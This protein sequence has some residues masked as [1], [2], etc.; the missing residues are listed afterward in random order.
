[1]FMLSAPMPAIATSVNSAGGVRRS[2]SLR[3]R[4][5]GSVVMIA[6]RMA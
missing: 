4:G 5:E 1:M 2:N 6:I 3:A